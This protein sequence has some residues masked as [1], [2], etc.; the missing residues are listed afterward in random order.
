MERRVFMES[1][2]V[3][4]IKSHI[5]LMIEMLLGSVVSFGESDRESLSIITFTLLLK[6]K[7]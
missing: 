5:K 3:C 6:Q 4:V 2:V 7:Y 1:S